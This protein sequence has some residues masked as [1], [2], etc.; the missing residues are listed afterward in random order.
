MTTIKI[1]KELKINFIIDK[2]INKIYLTFRD[3]KVEFNLWVRCINDLGVVFF[4]KEFIEID[5]ESGVIDVN[6]INIEE[7]KDIIIVD[8]NYN[9]KF[10]DYNEK[11][12]YTI[13]MNFNN[14]KKLIF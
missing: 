5:D 12:V 11:P 4:D 13:T 7:K 2:Q 8:E 9:F 3:Y 14:E 1:D 10:I 6:E